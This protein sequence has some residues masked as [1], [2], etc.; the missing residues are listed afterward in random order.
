VFPEKTI[1]A[2]SLSK[3]RKES[4]LVKVTSV[5]YNSPAPCV[6]AHVRPERAPK[7]INR[8]QQDCKRILTDKHWQLRCR[9]V[10]VV[11]LVEAIKPVRG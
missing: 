2:D 5:K 9:A 4:F 3:L 7:D 11:G 8:L 1:V 10:F 6:V